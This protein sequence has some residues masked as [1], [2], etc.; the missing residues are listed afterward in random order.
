MPRT[1]L[2]VSL[3]VLLLIVSSPKAL[4]AQFDFELPSI[5]EMLAEQLTDVARLFGESRR[6][7]GNVTRDIQAARKAFWAQYPNGPK[8]AEAEAAFAQKLFLKDFLVAF[9][10]MGGACVGGH[11]PTAQAMTEVMRQLGEID[12]GI[13]DRAIEDFC[14]WVDDLRK[15]GMSFTA[16]TQWMS[17]GPTLKSY[18]RYRKQRDW[19]E[20]VAAGKAPFAS[21][22][23]LWDSKNP[24]YQSLAMMMIVRDTT[25][26]S[27]P[28]RVVAADEL[29]NAFAKER[30]R[31][32]LLSASRR[33][34]AAPKSAD[35]LS[36][37]DPKAAQA[38]GCKSTSVDRCYHELIETPES[39]KAAAAYAAKVAAEAAA[40]PKT[41]PVT[42]DERARWA[43]LSD[44]RDPKQYALYLS[45]FTAQTHYTDSTADFRRDMA[46]KQ[47]A[48]WINQWGSER[49]MTAARMVREAPKGPQ[50]EL[51]S[52]TCLSLGCRSCGAQAQ[53]FERGL[54]KNP[55]LP[56]SCFQEL[57][58]SKFPLQPAAAA[59]PAAANANVSQILQAAGR[60]YPPKKI[61]HVDPIYPPEA[62][63]QRIGSVS[64]AMMI[65]V[66]VDGRVIDARMLTPAPV[67]E[68]AA[69]A[70]VKQWEYDA[71]GIRSPTNL[72]V[73]VPFVL[74][75]R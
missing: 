30:G 71:G 63:A 26:L 55:C 41:G 19:E 65:T 8:R 21:H 67:L 32:T 50:G 69:M 11:N 22:G 31:E 62:L 44:S 68:A 10:Y 72:Q 46:E 54:S 61:K 52:K 33:L 27:F 57:S 35:G 73:T 43:P 6:A 14:R 16:A 51:A 9:A 49:V 39:R 58:W 1:I 38:L 53:N 66:G 13:H 18:E 15:M 2:Y 25:E 34:I 12:G 56:N 20:F 42:E 48:G 75:K 74:P 70:A 28:E 40:A 4:N 60:S 3:V 37:R 24:Y 7:S 5:G 47:L 64:V 36:L 23:E 59:A 29:F 17:I 45:W